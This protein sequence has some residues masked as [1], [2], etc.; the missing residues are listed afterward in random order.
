[1]KSRAQVA[2]RLRANFSSAVRKAVEHGKQ[3]GLRPDLFA[4]HAMQNVWYLIGYIEH[5]EPELA[6]ALAR[7]VGD[8]ELLT[9][10][11]EEIQ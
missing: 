3:R 11:R 9:R 2:D 1:M 6:K 4:D 8:E 7:L 10:Q 5:H